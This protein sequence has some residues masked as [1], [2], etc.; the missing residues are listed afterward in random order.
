M[1]SRGD[2]VVVT[3]NYR[4]STLGFL[5]LE[6]STSRGNYWLS[7]QI[8]ALEW[9]QHH[10]E[11]FGGDKNKVTIFG[12]SAGGASVRALLASPRATGKFSRAIMQSCPAG[13]GYANSFARYS[14]IADAANQ[15]EAIFAEKGC[16]MEDQAD[17]LA[18]LRTVDAAKLVSG[19]VYSSPV[20]DGTYLTAPELLLD[21]SGPSLDIAL[22]T[23]VMHDD[24][25]PFTSFSKSPN[26][27]QALTSQG[28]DANAILGSGVFPV[29][30]SG[31]T[32]LDIF[33]LTSRVATDAEFRCLTQSTAY[34]A[35][36]NRVFPV[37]YSYE[38]DRSFQLIE[39]SPNPPTCEAPKNEEHP[40]GDTSLPYYK[41]HSGELYYEFGTARRQGREPRDQNDIPFS[42]YLLDT[43]TAFGRTTDPNP[44]LAFLHARGFTNTSTVVKKAALWKPTNA[45]ELKLRVHDL[46]PRNEDFRELEQCEVLEL[47]LDYYLQ[48]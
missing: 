24:G 40:L 26:A 8:S 27:T 9:V 42:Q 1:A 22:M 28:Y 30:Q 31:N 7:D 32:T 13:A 46:H 19:T 10:I 29:P 37:V 41:C 20:V 14:S 11:D 39:W 35:V 38:I 48:E 36:K 3:I 44:D 5:A 2:V 4:L 23:G 21:G 15:T 33:N 45:N 47:P 6:N 34:S 12:Q 25:D 18:C 43:W 16:G 17:Q